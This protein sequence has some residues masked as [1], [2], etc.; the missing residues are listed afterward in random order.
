MRTTSLNTDRKS[1][2]GDLAFCCVIAWEVSIVSS[3]IQGVS[4]LTE[5]YFRNRERK[6]ERGLNNFKFVKKITRITFSSF[7]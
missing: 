6:R 4:E 3:S 7:Y 5:R 1:K 2:D